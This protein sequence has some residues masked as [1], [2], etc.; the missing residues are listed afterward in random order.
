MN[1]S[2]QQQWAELQ[3]KVFNLWD[4]KVS[5]HYQALDEREQK[6]VRIAAIAL[7]LII[8][9][10]GILL[11]TLDKNAALRANIATL[12]V[13]VHEANQLADSLAAN[14]QVAQAGNESN[15]LGTVDKLARQTGVRSFMTR[16]RP[17]QVMGGEQRLQTQI[18]DAPYAKVAD[19]LA[20]LERS[21]LPVDQ[22]KIQASSE[23]LVHMQAVIGG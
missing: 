13:Q 9:V 8:F 20:T 7:P 14:P 18:K 6:V 17:Q 15:L 1:I 10:F 5:P 22:L 16:L 23:G 4:T 21:G 19:F 11:P 3:N 12:A 2:L